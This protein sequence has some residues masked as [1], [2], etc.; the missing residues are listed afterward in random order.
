MTESTMNGDGG[1]TTE[2]T[3]N[4]ALLGVFK[5]FFFAIYLIDCGS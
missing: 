5:V 3:I 1:I 4:F 2:S